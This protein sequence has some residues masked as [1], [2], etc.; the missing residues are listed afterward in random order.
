M[1]STFHSIETAR[2]SLFTQTAALNTTG[3]NIA[4]ANT[5]GYTRQRVNMTAS[6]PI[7][8][9][10]LNKS[11]V[12]GQLGTGVEFG[13]IDRIRETFLDTQYRGRIQHWEAG[14][15]NRIHWISWNPFLKNHRIQ[16]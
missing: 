1:T 15:S 14:R 9:Y 16:G 2:R 3:H 5:E 11:T 8:A 7:E 10:G 13:S 12:P 4:N 6:I